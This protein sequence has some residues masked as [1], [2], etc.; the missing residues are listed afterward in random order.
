MVK[1]S[2][3]PTWDGAVTQD[4]VLALLESLRCMHGRGPRREG[5]VV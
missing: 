3:L 4:S 5:R 1:V 2:W